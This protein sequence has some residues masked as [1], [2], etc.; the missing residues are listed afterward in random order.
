MSSSPPDTSSSTRPSATVAPVARSM[1]VGHRHASPRP[2]ARSNAS[3]LSPV[4]RRSAWNCRQ[5]SAQRSGGASPPATRIPQLAHASV[6]MRN[7]RRHSTSSTSAAAHRRSADRSF[8]RGLPCFGR[9]FVQFHAP[10]R[11]LVNASARPSPQ[12]ASVAWK[13]ELHESHTTPYSTTFL[14]DG[15]TL[16]CLVVLLRIALTN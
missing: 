14:H 10:W 5:H 9:Q 3:A 12:H 16:S 7:A 6:R 8:S 1:H 2:V 4:H 13:K 11:E 15:Q